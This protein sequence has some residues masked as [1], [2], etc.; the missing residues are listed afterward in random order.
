MLCGAKDRCCVVWGEGVVLH[1][2]R[3]LCCVARR[4][5]VVLCGVKVLCCMR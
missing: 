5:G 4:I 1:E 2:E 3:A